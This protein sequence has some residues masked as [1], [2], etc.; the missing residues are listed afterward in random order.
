MKTAVETKPCLNPLE[1]SI[2]DGQDFYPLEADK[3]KDC[4]ED[5]INAA[6]HDDRFVH[7]GLSIS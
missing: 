5:E 1:M 7:T 2:Q 6:T 4:S 3:G